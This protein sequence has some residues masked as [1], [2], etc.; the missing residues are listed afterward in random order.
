MLR[1]ALLSGEELVE[2]LMEQVYW[3][4]GATESATGAKT[5]TLR[6]FEEKYGAEFL[7][8]AH[9]N[10][11][12]NLAAIYELLPEGEQARGDLKDALRAL[13]RAVNIDWPLQHYRS[14]V[15]YL[16]N[17]NT[18]KGEPQGHAEAGVGASGGEAA[19]ATGGTNWQQYLPPR[20]QFRIFFPTLWSEEERKGW[21]A[22]H[23][24]SQPA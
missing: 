17:A 16:S 5:L 3:K 7:R 22:R 12:T 1:R 19:A 4:R 8:L 10:K 13:D 20:F 6:Q 15:R 9:E 24:P 18:G 23:S 14:A 11:A 21:G 2:Q